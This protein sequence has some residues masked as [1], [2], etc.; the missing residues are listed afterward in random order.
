MGHDLNR[1]RC[2]VAGR[3]QAMIPV[4]SGLIAFDVIGRPAPQGSK[5]RTQYGGMRESSKYLEPWRRK[6]SLAAREAM[7]LHPAGP[8]EFPLAGPLCLSI[9][10]RLSK[11][12]RNKETHAVKPPDLDKLVRGV[13]D[14]L[15]QSEIVGDDAQFTRF[16]EVYKRFLRPGEEQGAYIVISRDSGGMP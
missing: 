16:R 4:T 13:G 2:D 6:V 10:F 3:S 14:A 9:V 7:T 8:A 15:T 1:V 12:K 5:T 11:G